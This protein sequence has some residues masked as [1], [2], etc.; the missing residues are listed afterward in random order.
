MESVSTTTTPSWP[1]GVPGCETC[2]QFTL[3]R[4][5]AFH[6]KDYSLATDQNVLLV[7]HKWHAH[8]ER[9]HTP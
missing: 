1:E 3:E 7:R 5:A 6:R 9:K 2:E 8:P 4:E